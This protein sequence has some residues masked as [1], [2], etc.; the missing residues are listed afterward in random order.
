MLFIFTLNNLIFLK[1]PDSWYVSQYHWLFLRLDLRESEKMKLEN[2]QLYVDKMKTYL[3]SESPFYEDYKWENLKNFQDHW[4]LEEPDL[5][6]MYNTSFTSKYSGRL[7]GGS[8]NSAKAMMMEMIK[9]N[10]DFIRSAFKDFFNNEKEIMLRANRFSFHCDQAME[11]V[12]KINSKLV[13]HYHDNFKILSVY[14]T[15]KYPTEYC[16]FDYKAFKQMMKKLEVVEIPEQYEVDRFFK[17][18]KNLYNIISEDQEFV[19]LHKSKIVG[20]AFYQE[21]SMLLVHD[22]YW[23]CT[24][25]EYGIK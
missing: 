6:K 20:E 25:P 12:R 22:F 11:E 7:W 14:L 1:E 2:I 8:K 10:P 3:Q 18:S 4:D 5:G 17:I 13:K 24:R 21:A 23:C 16:I 9:I 19:E 15:F